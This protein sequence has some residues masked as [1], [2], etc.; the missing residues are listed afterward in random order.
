MLKYRYVVKNICIK[1]VK[2]REQKQVTIFFTTFAEF[3]VFPIGFIL[4][5]DIKR[6]R[7]ILPT[8]Q[9]RVEQRS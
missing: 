3:S 8:P 9:W 6:I 2:L 5:I 7:S 4:F 1:N